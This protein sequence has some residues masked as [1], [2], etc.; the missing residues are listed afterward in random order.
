MKTFLYLLMLIP[1]TLKMCAGSDV[2]EDR[3]R[4][5]KVG[6]ES[7]YLDEALEGMPSG[8]SAKDSALFVKQYVKTRVK[9]LLVYE[10]AQKNI[11]QGKEIDELVE[12]YRRS[13]IIYEY[14]QQVLNEK[15]QTEISET[16][17]QVFYENNRDRFV[18]EHNLIKGVFIK[19]PKSSPDLAQLKKWYKST[20]TEAFQKMESFCVQNGGQFEHFCDKWIIF[21]DILDNI[22]HDI[23]RAS[24]FLHNHAALD[25]T[26]GDYCYLLYVDDYVLA[27]TTAPFEFVK[28]DVRNIMV[29]TRKTDFIHR[30][31]SSLLKEAEKKG[32]I[33]YYKVK[34]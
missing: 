30:F 2:P 25:I 22:P 9:D 15:M 12:N 28:D 32:T 26:E 19:V 1:L 18:A 6:S 31:E 4:L 17:M 11:P 34:K 10:K 20:S 3:I 33:T 24:D 14:Q 7:V 8:L 29:N 13:L 5:A 27:G 21:D 23:G 16:E